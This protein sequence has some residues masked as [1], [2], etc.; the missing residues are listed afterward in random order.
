MKLFLSR[1]KIKNI[2]EIWFLTIVKVNAENIKQGKS[3]QSYKLAF[4]L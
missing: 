1:G 3:I 4:T 2:K